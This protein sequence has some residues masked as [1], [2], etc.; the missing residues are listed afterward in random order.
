VFFADDRPY[1]SAARIRAAVWSHGNAAV[2][3][4]LA[5]AWWLDLIKDAPS[6]V[7]VTVP[8]NSHSRS[9]R[10]T[11]LRRRDLSERD[12]MEHRRLRLTGPALTVIEAS[13][14]PGGGADIM[15][16]ALQR[17]MSLADLQRAGE[18]NKG[19]HGSV[20]IRRLLAAAASGARSEA[21]RLLVQLFESA[22]ITGWYSNCP[23]GGYVVDFAFPVP[24]VAIEVDGWAFHTDPEAF[25][26]DRER[27]NKLA[28]MGWQV[29]RFTWLDLVQHSDRVLAQVVA[30]ISR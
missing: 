22:G 7:E 19:G 16:S 25:Q 2:A 17:G 29:L 9:S 10:G 30:A 5:A 11:Q 24:M 1:T 21:E 8:R 14:A 26:R 6:I 13:V 28:L 18:R 27:Q 12:V 3:S 20:A 15:D 4:G 23:V